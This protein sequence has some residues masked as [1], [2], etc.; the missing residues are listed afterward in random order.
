MN[1]WPPGQL[2]L[3]R[4][5]SLTRSHGKMQ[6]HLRSDKIKEIRREKLGHGERRDIAWVDHLLSNL[7]YIIQIFRESAINQHLLRLWSGFFFLVWNSFR[8][9]VRIGFEARVL[10]FSENA[11]FSGCIPSFNR[12]EKFDKRPTRIL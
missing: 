8:I 10:S 7:H 2:N 12:A 3:T 1:G 6:K 11:D 9:S 5:K 4:C